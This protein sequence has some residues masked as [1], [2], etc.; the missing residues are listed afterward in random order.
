MRE[1]QRRESVT[2]Q[3]SEYAEDRWVEGEEH[4]SWELVVDRQECGLTPE[5]GDGD[6][7]PPL[8]YVHG[9]Y[10]GLTGCPVTSRIV[11]EEETRGFCRCEDKTIGRDMNICPGEPIRRVG[12]RTPPC[13]ATICRK[14]YIH[15]IP[16][17]YY[18]LSIGLHRDRHPTLT[19]R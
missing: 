18:C 11:G 10:C 4:S 5:S 3:L 2:S 1:I 6:T 12:R 15:Q 14:I 7:S 19:V 16:D 13:H 17:S 9:S 8:Q